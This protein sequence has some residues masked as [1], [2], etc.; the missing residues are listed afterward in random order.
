MAEAF[1]V[2]AAR[3]AGGRK[4]GRLSGW[5]PVDLAAQVLDALVDRGG[6]WPGAGYLLQAGDF[7]VE[8]AAQRGDGLRPQSGQFPARV[9]EPVDRGFR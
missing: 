8:M 9:G 2:A 5:H 1:I 3:T 4:G 7:A 6:R